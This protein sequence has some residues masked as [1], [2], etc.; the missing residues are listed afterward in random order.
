[1]QKVAG[2]MSKTKRFEWTEAVNLLI[3]ALAAPALCFMLGLQI[4][5]RDLADLV[6]GGDLATHLLPLRPGPVAAFP[7]RCC[8]QSTRF[9]LSLDE[10]LRENHHFKGLP[11]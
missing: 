3:F 9:G 7:L 5:V 11:C 10:S 8:V 4:A 1:M 2:V 6:L